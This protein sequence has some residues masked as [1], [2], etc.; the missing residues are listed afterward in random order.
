VDGV[1]MKVWLSTTA[2]RKL[3]DHIVLV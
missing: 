1:K 3:P 2:L